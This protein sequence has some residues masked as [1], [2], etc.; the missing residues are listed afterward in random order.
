MINL[1]P[2]AVN[3]IRRLLS[4]QGQQNKL[5]RLQIQTG[6]C[7]G[8]FYDMSFDEALKPGD[9]LYDCTGIP[10]VV[11][12]Q[13]LNYVS[14]LTIDYSEDLLGGGFRF[15]NPN[16]VKSCGCGNSFSTSPN[17]PI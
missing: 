15:H 8:L 11:D 7:S 2:P 14:G 16:A 4:K 6:G 10:V 17:S 3:E 5:F 12:A 1:S 13:S 9:R